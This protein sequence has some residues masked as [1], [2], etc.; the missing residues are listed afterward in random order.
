METPAKV[1]L[2]KDKKYSYCTC[3]KSADKTFCDGSHKGTDFK[4]L[5][6]SVDEDKEYSICRCKKT[7]NPPFCDGSHR[8]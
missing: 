1:E 8:K 6:F 3:G 7:S 2:Q 4:P 5:R